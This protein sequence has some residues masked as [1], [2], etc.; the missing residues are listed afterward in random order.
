MAGPC[1]SAYPKLYIAEIFI[2]IDCSLYFLSC[3]L[4]IT[5]LATLV[6]CFGGC[7]VL[8]CAGIC[9]AAAAAEDNDDKISGSDKFARALK[10]ATR[11]IS[12]NPY[13]YAPEGLCQECHSHILDDE[14][15]A[16][17]EDCGH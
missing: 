14:K 2:L 4:A 16:T 7:A 17:L 11:T 6:C 9:C 15:S 10:G 8:G 13:D 5:C 12:L 1:A 3:I